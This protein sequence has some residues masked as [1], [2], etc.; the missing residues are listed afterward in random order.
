MRRHRKSKTAEIVIE[1]RKSAR[2]KRKGKRR[3]YD[4]IA[5]LG[6]ERE[7][8]RQTIKTDHAVATTSHQHV[9]I[10][11]ESDSV[12]LCW[13]CHRKFALFFFLSRKK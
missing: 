6:K 9:A 11:I 7:T 5:F 12:N 10:V 8:D 2:E 13:I 3:H 4:T 1:K